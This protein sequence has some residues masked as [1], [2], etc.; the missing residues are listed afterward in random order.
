MV[1]MPVFD[2]EGIRNDTTCTKFTSPHLE[3]EPPGHADTSQACKWLFGEMTTCCCMFMAVMSP[4]SFSSNQNLNSH[5]G[6]NFNVQ[7]N[8]MILYLSYYYANGYYPKLHS[9]AFFLF[10]AKKLS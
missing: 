3:I 4:N 10:K 9:H 7:N 8:V 5:N 6:A 1:K 2:N